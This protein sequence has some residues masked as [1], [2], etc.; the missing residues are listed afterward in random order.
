MPS[1]PGKPALA[2]SEG[3]AF[4]QHRKFAL[5]KTAQQKLAKSEHR[6]RFFTRMGEPRNAANKWLSA[7]VL[8]GDDQVYPLQKWIAVKRHCQRITRLVPHLL[9][10]SAISR[11]IGID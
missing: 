11:G 5:G 10:Y 1:L 3:P 2:K 8:L 9:T 7:A 6:M 4:G